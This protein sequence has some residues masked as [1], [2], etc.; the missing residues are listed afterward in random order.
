[1]SPAPAVAPA[2]PVEIVP[3]APVVTITPPKPS[4]CDTCPSKCAAH[5]QACNS[6]TISSC[7]ELGAC[8][9][10]CKLAEGGC[11][12]GKP[13]L[14]ECISTNRA[15]ARSKPKPTPDED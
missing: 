4:A 5:K 9:C 6:G 1:M 15:K 7:Y 8:L 10:E 11:G 14:R 2:P 12:D 13:A 3:T